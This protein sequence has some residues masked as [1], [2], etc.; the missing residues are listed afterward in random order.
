MNSKKLITL[1]VLTTM[2]LAMV[3]M[4]PVANA[5]LA[6]TKITMTNDSKPLLVD[7]NGERVTPSSSRVDLVQLP[8]ATRSQPTGIRSSPGTESKVT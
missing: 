5:V 8:Q 2:L 1:L 7:N 4:V 6:D 3:P